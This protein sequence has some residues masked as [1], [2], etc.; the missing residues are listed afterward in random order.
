MPQSLNTRPH[1][2]LL[3]VHCVCLCPPESKT[4]ASLWLSTLSYTTL[5]P[6]LQECVKPVKLEKK[7]GKSLARI[8][9]EDDGTYIQINQVGVANCLILRSLGRCSYTL[10][11]LLGWREEEAGEGKDHPERLLGL[12]RLHH[13][14]RERPHHSA[15]PRGALE[16]VAKQHG[17][18]H[19]GACTAAAEGFFG[20]SH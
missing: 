18:N 1:F 14:G 10:S 16:S 15:E 6:F 20:L 3:L 7:Q 5:L 19:Q 2:I 17:I 8:Q 12:Q 9:I 11:L 4:A 13:L